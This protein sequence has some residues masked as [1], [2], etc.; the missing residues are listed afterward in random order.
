MGARVHSYEN[1]HSRDASLKRLFRQQNETTEEKKY[2]L[3]GKTAEIFIHTVYPSRLSLWH[4]STRNFPWCIIRQRISMNDGMMIKYTEVCHTSKS[5]KER[6]EKKHMT[7]PVCRRRYFYLLH[8]RLRMCIHSHSHS[9]SP[10]SSRHW[11][12]TSLHWKCF[13]LW[14]EF[15]GSWLYFFPSFAHI[16]F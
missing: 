10:H 4:V 7:D 14:A 12:Q 13:S 5:E 1:V 11:L 8:S 16:Y 3:H 2:Y 6:R 9:H 15:E